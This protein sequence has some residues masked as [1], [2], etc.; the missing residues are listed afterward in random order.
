MTTLGT[1]G[2]SQTWDTTAFSPDILVGQA[3]H[4]RMRDLIVVCLFSLV[5][6]TVSAVVLSYLSDETISLMFS[7]IG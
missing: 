1:I 4:P 6:L 5:G 2:R 3:A 7:S